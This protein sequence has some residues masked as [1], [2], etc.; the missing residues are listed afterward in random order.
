[1]GD[2]ASPKVGVVPKM[3]GSGELPIV[4]R[5]PSRNI[6]F[7]SAEILTIPEL[8]QL[9]HIKTEKET[10]HVRVTGVILHLHLGMPINEAIRRADSSVNER[11]TSWMILG[12]ALFVPQK[13]IVLPSNRRTRS[14]VTNPRIATK[15][16]GI[17]TK[18]KNIV[19][20]GGGNR[21]KLGATPLLSGKKRKLITVKPNNN[22]LL[23]RGNGNSRI[24]QNSK[25][26]SDKTKPNLATPSSRTSASLSASI[27]KQKPQSTHSLPTPNSRAA[28]DRTLSRINEEVR[29]KSRR[30]MNM[31][32]VNIANMSCIDGCKEGDLAMV[33]G[34]VVL[35]D[36]GDRK[37]SGS[38]GSNSASED[39]KRSGA[40]NDESLDID[41]SSA[42]SDSLDRVT[43][44]VGT[45]QIRIMR[46][47]DTKKDL[48]GDQ[49]MPKSPLSATNY[50]SGYIDARI[51]KVVN[52]TDMSLFQKALEMRREYLHNNI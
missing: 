18:P 48:N 16:N 1:M 45:C 44:L 24:L 13:K 46:D 22:S 30:G 10:D 38:F 11:N 51:L 17:A 36:D 32:V 9:I 28:L 3:K 29:Q 26:A 33:M 41:T 8:S 50:R 12:D 34:S 2:I 35:L 21:S 27:G 42:C 23:G 47:T 15:N 40:T 6:S 49:T 7:Q 52:G 19:M 14:I 37:N 25:K 5:L 20:N 4:E 31:V 39:T 43:K